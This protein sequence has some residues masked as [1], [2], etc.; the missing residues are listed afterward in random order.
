[1]GK[2]FNG[3]SRVTTVRQANEQTFKFCLYLFQ[4]KMIFLDLDLAHSHLFK[5]LKKDIKWKRYSC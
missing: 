3:N 1:M 5:L 2:K 4:I